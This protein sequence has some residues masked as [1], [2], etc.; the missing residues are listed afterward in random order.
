[1]DK[2]VL[3][4][5][6]KPIDFQPILVQERMQQLEQIFANSTFKID[7]GLT[8]SRLGFSTYSVNQTIN[9]RYFL[10]HQI[11]CKLYCSER[12]EAKDTNRFPF[13]WFD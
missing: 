1:M 8:M 11:K 10:E 4:Q 13:S 5:R 12:I 7:S 9:L 3:H 2:V 6:A